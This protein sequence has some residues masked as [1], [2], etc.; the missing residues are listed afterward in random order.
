MDEET[1]ELILEEEETSFLIR[2]TTPLTNP[3]SFNFGTDL[4]EYLERCYPEYAECHVRWH[5]CICL[6]MKNRKLDPI[7]SHA[8]HV[9]L[10]DIGVIPHPTRGLQIYREEE[11]DG[12]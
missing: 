5:S 1:T 6:L 10:R 3:Y 7:P 8:V 4:Y 12:K 2:G 9:W 11:D